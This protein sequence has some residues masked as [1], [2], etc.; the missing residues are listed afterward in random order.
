MSIIVMDIETRGSKDLL[1]VYL[2]N[3]K[4]PKNLKD[5]AKIEA[6][7]EEKRA[8]AINDMAVDPDFNEII[9]I[10]IKELDK[11]PMLLSLEEY[12]EWLNETTILEYGAKIQNMYKKLVTFNGKQFDLQVIMRAGIKA[13]IKLPYNYLKGLTDKY[14]KHHLDLMQEL[15]TSWGQF[16]SLDKY[17]QIYLG[18]KKKPI[19]FA[20]ATEK[21]IKEHCVEDLN[22]TYKLLEKFKPLFFNVYDKD[23][24]ATK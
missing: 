18:I 8:E 16:K 12:A 24:S 4:A 1:E 5:P 23:Y 11:E 20:T 6:Y 3:I 21:E 19:D 15:S 10:G 9:C 22:N 17:L 7:L 13:G 14:N 2:E